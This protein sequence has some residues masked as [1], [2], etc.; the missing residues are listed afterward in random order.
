MRIKSVELVALPDAPAWQEKVRARLDTGEDMDLFSSIG[1][2]RC[3]R[4]A[5]SA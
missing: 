5:W 2:C 1:T 3:H 4:K